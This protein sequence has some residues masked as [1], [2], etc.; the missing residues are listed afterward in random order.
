VAFFFFEEFI[1]NVNTTVSMFSTMLDFKS[2]G[3]IR[4]EAALILYDVNVG[5]VDHYFPL[6]LQEV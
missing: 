2:Q 3:I 6:T 5:P 4:V 1:N